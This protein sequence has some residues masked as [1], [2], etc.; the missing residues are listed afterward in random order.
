MQCFAGLA[1]F[2][3][4]NVD[5]DEVERVEQGVA[6]VLANVLNVFSGSAKTPKPKSKSFQRTTFKKLTCKTVV[7]NDSARRASR[8]HQPADIP[9]LESCC[10]LAPTPFF[11]EGRLTVCTFA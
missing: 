4:D 8:I 9:A 5:P 7:A 3:L 6:D 1:V 10:C 2:L 11:L